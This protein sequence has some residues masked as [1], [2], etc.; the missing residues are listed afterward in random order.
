MCAQS[1]R[2]GVQASKLGIISSGGDQNM[3]GRE[4]SSS[5]GDTID[6]QPA[7]PYYSWLPDLAP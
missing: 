3:P 5:K 6:D 1:Q 4:R 7:P 2:V